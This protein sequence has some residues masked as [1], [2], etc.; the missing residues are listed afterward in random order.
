M[1]RKFPWAA[2]RCR[3]GPGTAGLRPALALAA[4]ALAAACFRPKIPD[5]VVLCA[6][7][8]DCYAGQTCQVSADRSV[9]LCCGPDGCPG[10]MPVPERP[11]DAAPPPVETGPSEP[12]APPDAAVTPEASPPDDAIEAP[13]QRDSLPD[14]AGAALVT[15]TPPA[16]AGKR[17]CT[18]EA[19]ERDVR[20]YLDGVS[21]DDP[22]TLVTQG[23]CTA[24]LDLGPKTTAAP[25][26]P[27]APLGND[28]LQ[29]FTEVVT[30]YRAVCAD[31]GGDEVGAFATGWAR[32]LINAAEVKATFQARTG[33]PLEVPTPAQ[34][35][36]QRYLGAARNRP[37]W[38]VV[39]ARGTGLRVLWRAKEAAAP[40]EIV[41]SNDLAVA[42]D[43]F[44]GH[45][46]YLNHLPAR[47]AYK[48]TLRNELATRIPAWMSEI[49]RDSLAENLILD[50][51]DPTFAL[52]VTEALRNGPNWDDVPTYE[53]KRAEAAGT[54]VP[55]PFGTGWT[56]APADDVTDLM[57]SISDAQFLALRGGERG[58]A[59]GLYV[60]G[61]TSFLDLF[62]R[63][64]SP[65]EIGL[66][67]V[68]PS[69]GYLLRKRFAR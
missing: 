7:D 48:A 34:E 2:G 15:C 46:A 61:L 64:L 52:A 56:P 16:T 54:L 21:G 36:E 45:P 9:R 5:A 30:Y 22:L 35:I 55:T 53:R 44:F 37:G 28:D 8:S 6:A 58:R 51:A 20:L 43:M 63:E 18:I 59:Y 60:L 49:A 47:A 24:R 67:Q 11:R 66:V 27:A 62:A 19:D 69:H 39:H 3:P 26:R 14:S 10:V 23:T 31:L 38:L 12:P 50:A 32:A 13:P 68:S 4:V 41:I 29:L 25:G 17:Y 57:T 40:T 33:L 65:D 1:H 42:D